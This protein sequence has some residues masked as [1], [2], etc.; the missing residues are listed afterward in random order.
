MTRPYGRPEAPKCVRRAVDSNLIKLMAENGGTEPR[1]LRSD[2]GSTQR[3]GVT[4]RPKKKDPATVI[5]AGFF[6]GV[7]SSV[8][9]KQS[10]QP[11]LHLHAIGREDSGFVGGIGGL[12]GN[13]IAAA[14]QALERCLLFVDEG[15]DNL[16]GGGGVLFL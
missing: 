16:S 12:Q 10:D 9:A 4:L 13:R 1:D 11:A 2:G 15:D 5:G 8:L 14:A 3:A 6:V 7:L